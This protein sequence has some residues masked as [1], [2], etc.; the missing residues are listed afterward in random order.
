MKGGQAGEIL[1]DQGK[2][3][4]EVREKLK[5]VV[6]CITNTAAI[7]LHYRN[8]KHPSLPKYKL[9]APGRQKKQIQAV[10]FRKEKF[11]RTVCISVC[12]TAA[13]M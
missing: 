10:V 1:V 12:H 2:D 11:F 7:T 4:N 13:N 5:D 6:G 9:N 8:S 3:A